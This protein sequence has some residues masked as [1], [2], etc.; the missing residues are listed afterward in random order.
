MT[1]QAASPCVLRVLNGA[2]E[3]LRLEWDPHSGPLVAGRDPLGCQLVLHDEHVSGRHVELVF[4]R[5]L[6]A[7][8]MRDLGSTNGS[9]LLR[10]GRLWAVDATHPVPLAPIERLVLGDAATPVVIH[11]FDSLEREHDLEQ[12]RVVAQTH[13]GRIDDV[14]GRLRADPELLQRI[15]VGTKRLARDL[16]LAAV[17]EAGVEIF[18]EC[19]EAATHVSI[20][21][22]SEHR[23]SI[24]TADL[25]EQRFIPLVCVRRDGT[26]ETPRPLSRW[27]R[28]RILEAGTGILASDAAHDFDASRSLQ[29][30]D[31]AAVIAAPL[32]IGERVIGIVQLDRRTSAHE[33][34]GARK[35]FTSVDLELAMVLAGQ[36]ALAVEHARL[37]QRL[38]VSEDR[39]RR[40]NSFL[41]TREAES[42]RM[43]GNAAAMRRVLDLIDRVKDTTVPVC[44]LGETGTGKELVAR[45]IHHRSN[46]S[47]KLFVAQ[48]CA[49]LPEDLL[50]SEL[51]GHVRGA[52]TG[53]DSDKK[54]LFEHA[55]GGTIFLD[56]IG[57]TTPAM[58]AK[59]LRVLQEGEVRPVGSG[60]TRRVDVRVISATNRNLEEEVAE[61]RFREDLYYRLVVFPIRLPPLRDR[62]DD[63]PLLADYFMRRYAAEFARAPLTFTAAALDVLKSYKWPG[64]IRELQNEI[65]RLIICGGQDSDFIEPSDLSPRIRTV[66]KAL[67]DA[68]DEPAWTLRD[69]LANVERY[70]LIEALREHD[71]NK[72][73]TAEALG[74]TREGLHKKLTRYGI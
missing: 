68:G 9:R 58:Q 55:H 38:L 61:G 8:V 4:D 42:T 51:F 21:L 15:Y 57:E 67:G 56:E 71:N 54:G 73:R 53:A 45:T 22:E 27:L 24:A 6:G 13:I 65:Q 36:L 44:I 29:S 10:D 12:T 40:E 50:E 11:F 37:Y 5:E 35:T 46:R 19:L 3:G 26:A 28:K 63:I 41:K 43:I 52:F 66:E 62:R 16:D 70:M 74:I 47:D 69:R 30:L 20:L 2:S 60:R 64:N 49:A 33:A 18:F 7:I 39:L 72:T 31:I 14:E 25:D 1:T 34:V 59:L 17:L 23:S 32:W 48:N